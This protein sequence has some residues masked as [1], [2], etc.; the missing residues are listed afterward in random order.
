MMLDQKRAAQA[1]R[2]VS[3]LPKGDEHKE[4][5]TR[6]GTTAL[7]LTALIR[8]AGLCQAV[9]FIASRV[10]KDESQPKKLNPYELFLNHLAG[11]LTRLNKD[12]TD[13]NT[14]CAQIRETSLA[15]YVHLTREALAVANWYGRLARS[16]LNIDPTDQTGDEHG[17]A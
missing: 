11:Q 12:I 2:D 4:F 16:E 13:K 5:R 1:Y 15:N 6:Y 10:K 8:S 14:L 3:G 7:N 9:H 17:P